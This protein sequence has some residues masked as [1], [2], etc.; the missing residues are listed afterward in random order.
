MPASASSSAAIGTVAPVGAGGGLACPASS[1]RTLS[2]YSIT[3]LC[4]MA[5]PPLVLVII[6][7]PNLLVLPLALAPPVA[8]SVVLYFWWLRAAAPQDE[9]F[10]RTLASAFY[11]GA[12]VCLLAE[13]G[14][15]L[16][17]ALV[18]LGDSLDAL[19]G[20][21]AT[22]PAGHS[23]VRRAAALRGKAGFWIF[24]VLTA[25]VTAATTEELAK[26][27][28]VRLPCLPRRLDGR[29]AALC[30]QRRRSYSGDASA[31]AHAT[32]A[33]FL[34]AAIGFSAAENLLYIFAETLT[35]A[36]FTNSL[37]AVAGKAAI[38]AVRGVV[39]MP[40]HCVCAAFTALRLAVRDGQLDRAD[41]LEE[42][43]SKGGLY[44]FVAA[45]PA[46]ADGTG[47]GSAG[48]AG[49]GGAPYSRRD[50]LPPQAEDEGDG[51]GDD[52]TPLVRASTSGGG[53]GGAAASRAA[54]AAASAS[55]GGGSWQLTMSA[56][57]ARAA[58]EAL[59]IWSWPRVLW[60]A[61]VVHGVFDAQALLLAAS[62][63][64]TFGEG[65]ITSLT[66]L[67]GAF[68]LVF[69][70]YVLCEQYAVVFEALERS[71]EAPGAVSQGLGD[72]RRFSARA[73]RC[74]CCCCAAAGGSGGGCCRRRSSGKPGDDDG[75]GGDDYDDDDGGVGEVV[76]RTPVAMDDA[77]SAPPPDLP[78]R[79]IVIAASVVKVVR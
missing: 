49:G 4:L 50:L 29:D 52:D 6:D 16:L 18:C 66:L 22:D 27:A 5:V 33:L 78:E 1:A 65:L 45:A 21:V 31:R 9:L 23:L 75:G 15:T 79:N 76:R 69:A 13:A 20:A 54:A 62:L 58:A 77:P 28:V 38:A 64:P 72:C 35:A 63:A 56:A 8:L 67:L 48:S 24:L 30:V 60:P 51:E 70:L 32:L 57:E 61:I 17:W 68:T 59:T 14:L 41:E 12:L 36:P 37:A 44:R 19:A 2:P 46:A 26:A 34:A 3:L 74:C 39:S 40:V 47:G 42:A 7:Y 11:P 73:R 43:A 55:A 53:G 71:G 25:F 10:V